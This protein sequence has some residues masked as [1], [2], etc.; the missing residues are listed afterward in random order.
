MY[1]TPSSRRRTLQDMASILDQSLAIVLDAL[2]GHVG[3]VYLC[4]ESGEGGT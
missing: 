2:D 1:L 4:A 3:G